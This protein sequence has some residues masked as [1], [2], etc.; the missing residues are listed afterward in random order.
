MNRNNCFCYY[1]NCNKRFKNYVYL[2]THI[3]L[4]HLKKKVIKC[5]ICGC[6]FDSDESYEM[7]KEIE[8]GSRCCVKDGFFLSRFEIGESFEY[9]PPDILS[10]PVLPP[11]SDDRTR[12]AFQYK[13][14]LSVKVFERLT[15][16]NLS[17]S[18]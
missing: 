12:G 3:N 2:T 16:S 4:Q 6:Y 13:L 11:I 5:E 7:H 8:V 15:S 10:L 1:Q 14:P 18:N 17:E 9:S